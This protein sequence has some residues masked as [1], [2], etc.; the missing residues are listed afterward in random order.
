MSVLCQS[1][2]ELVTRHD[3]APLTLGRRE[4]KNALNRALSDTVGRHSRRA[5]TT[6]R[7]GYSCRSPE[8]ARVGPFCRMCRSLVVTVR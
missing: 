5:S 1:Y 8:K 4:A 6:R 2:T 7:C 3:A